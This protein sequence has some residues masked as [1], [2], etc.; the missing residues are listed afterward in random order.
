MG[1]AV[2]NP[3]RRHRASPIE[4]TLA[5]RSR[6]KLTKDGKAFDVVMVADIDMMGLPFVWS[7]R[8]QGSKD[9]YFDNVTFL[10]NAVD[11]LVGDES[12]VEL[13][14][15]RPRERPL[16]RIEERETEFRKTWQ[17]EVEDAETEAKAQL[18]VAQ[19]R[20][21]G[22]I[23]E[24]RARTDLDA[25]SKE[26][27]MEATAR[28]ERRRL[29][30]AKMNVEDEKQERVE[31]AKGTMNA[32]VRSIQN[33]YRLLAVGVTPIPAIIA[34]LFVFILRRVREAESV[35]P[36]RSLAGGSAPPVADE[37]GATTPT[38]DGSTEGGS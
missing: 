17:R 28:V 1:G 33:R 24:I 34:A 21:D 27:R 13:R 20:L 10:L 30:L 2:L 36:E 19:N 14:K 5:C 11:S 12:F 23:E 26:I 16:K 8:E 31:R 37:P 6:G 32:G 25:R 35:P 3:N 15:R 7:L 9:F 38:D 18:E 22:A 29:A 4:L